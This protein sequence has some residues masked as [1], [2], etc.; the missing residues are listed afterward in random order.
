MQATN[1]FGAN[2]RKWPEKD[3]LFIKLQGGTPTILKE[4]SKV[5]QGI[6]KKHGGT[7][8]ELARTPQEAADLWADR[9]NAHFSTNALLPGCQSW[10]TDVWY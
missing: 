1:K 3:T 5:V 9:K 8:Y 4:T 6:A 7:G 10:P 2:T